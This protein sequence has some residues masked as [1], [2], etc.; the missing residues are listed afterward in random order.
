M[1]L[2]PGDPIIYMKVGTH[3]QEDL[4]DILARKRQEIER[5]GFGMWG[6]GGNT[7]HPKSMVQPF[8]R[9]A[10]KPIVLCMQPM[11]SRH[12]AEPVRAEEYSVDGRHW[13]QIPSGINVLGSRFALC[14]GS[15][16]DVDITLDLGDTRV[17]LGNHR[18]RNGSSYVQGRVDKACLE[19][20]APGSEPVRCIKIRAVAE[21]VEPFAVMVRN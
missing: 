12:R 4:A 3:A 5:E 8:A 16:E 10:G 18:G 11:E 19:V 9:T 15:L 2:Q 6:Y 14:I 20:I 7:C 13:K 1:I 21:I 17:A